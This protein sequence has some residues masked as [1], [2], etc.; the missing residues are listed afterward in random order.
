[1]TRC[2][3]V[4]M[5][6]FRHFSGKRPSMTRRG[7]CQI[8]MAPA[9]ATQAMR[10]GSRWLPDHCQWGVLWRR[11]RKEERWRE[12]LVNRL[13]RGKGGTSQLINQ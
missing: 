2:S 8:G 6:R 13:A 11:F 10:Q 12:Q 9:G 5:V 1:M 7:G 3:A 4:L